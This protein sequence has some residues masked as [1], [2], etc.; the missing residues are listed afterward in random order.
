VLL[1]TIGLAA[2]PCL[3]L[4]LF[5]VRTTGL[6][7]IEDE[8]IAGFDQTYWDTSN[9]GEEV[10]RPN[11]PGWSHRRR[12]PHA[13]PSAIRLSAENQRS[14][15]VMAAT[16]LSTRMVEVPAYEVHSHVRVDPGR[17]ALVVVDMQNDFVSR[18]GSL[19]VPDAKAT[20]PAIGVLLGARPYAW[21]AFI[22][23]QDTHRD[24]DPEW[25]I[26]GEHCREG[27]W[28]W[29]IVD[30][31]A[32]AQDDTVSKVRYD[33]FYGTP[34]DHFLRL[35][36]VETLAICGTVANVCVHD[37]IASA[38]LRWYEVVI[39]RDAISA[40]DAFDMESSLRQTAF[41]FAGRVTTAAGVRV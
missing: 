26:W 36:C 23:S 22:Y 35:W 1:L 34:L 13:R 24:G 17:T 19:R 8:E 3:L 15:D 7:V 28:G 41:L 5:F 11:R 30:A 6:Q 20:I 16:T 39:P 14:G 21:D 12:G 37:T 27:S 10:L 25:R 40:L 4:C 29:E 31:V 33:A 9:F 18:D 38:A 2:V 32:P